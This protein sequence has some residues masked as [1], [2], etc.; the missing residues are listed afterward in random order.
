M[1][2]E[3]SNL[4]ATLLTFFF[5]G[6]HAPKETKVCQ[7]WLLYCVVYYELLF[8]D[9]NHVGQTIRLQQAVRATLV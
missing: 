7:L 9:L 2:F 1:M 5:C 8:V 3:Q 6:G 4:L